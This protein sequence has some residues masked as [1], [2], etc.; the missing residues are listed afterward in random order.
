M[1]TAANLAVVRVVRTVGVTADCSAVPTDATTAA[2]TEA[3]WEK[4]KVE[5]RVESWVERWASTASML[6]V[7]RADVTGA[8]TVGS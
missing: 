8:M 3:G 2:T 7:L 4:M 5:K 6:A 1:R